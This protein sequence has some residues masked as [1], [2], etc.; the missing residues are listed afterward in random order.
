MGIGMIF[1]LQY[2]T[3]RVDG[4]RGSGITVQF[5]QNFVG[6]QDAP[7]S[8]KYGNFIKKDQVFISLDGVPDRKGLSVMA[9]YRI[10]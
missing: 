9:F 7:W 3:S 2:V 8:K 10:I 1:K 5:K 4:S 6:T